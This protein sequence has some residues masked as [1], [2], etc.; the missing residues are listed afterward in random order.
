[1]V[2]CIAGWNFYNPG[3]SYGSYKECDDGNLIE[4][5]GCST[6]CTINLGWKCGG[7]TLSS[8][9]KCTEICG[10]GQNYGYH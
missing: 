8:P 10:D 3:S 9:D 6:L 1:M 4:D 7:G 2:T 5:D